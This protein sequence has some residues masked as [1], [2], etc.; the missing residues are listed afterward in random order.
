MAEFFFFIQRLQNKFSSRFRNQHPVQFPPAP[1]NQADHVRLPLTA[2]RRPPFHDSPKQLVLIL[3]LTDIADHIHPSNRAGLDKLHRDGAVHTDI[4]QPAAPRAG[5]RNAEPLCIPRIHDIR[6]CTDDFSGMDM[7]KRPI[8]HSS[9]AQLF[10]RTRCIRAVRF[11]IRMKHGD[12]K[13]VILFSL[14]RFCQ[15][16]SD[17]PRPITDSVHR[18]DSL[19]A[20]CQRQSL[21]LFRRKDM[22]LRRQRN[23]RP[24]CFGGI[25]IAVSDKNLYALFRRPVQFAGKSHL[26][27]QAVMVAVIDIPGDQDRIGMGF[28]RRVHNTLKGG[29]RCFIHSVCPRAFFFGIH[30]SQRLAQMQIRA[31]YKRKM[32]SHIS[33]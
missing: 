9:R 15:I 21:G 26:R 31:V 6:R 19:S 28:H 3:I 4:H 1:E 7:T 13:S 18:C 8:I 22:D 24:P 17:V 33:S 20:N 16:F 25:M 32:F 14:K 10:F 27:R 12:R 29:K 11:H 23:I 30:P 2:Q 5:L